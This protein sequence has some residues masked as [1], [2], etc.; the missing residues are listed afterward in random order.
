MRVF[1]ELIVPARRPMADGVW[2][3][4]SVS[5]VEIPS[6]ISLQSATGAAYDAEQQVWRVLTIEYLEDEGE[7]NDDEP[8]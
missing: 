7:V 4:S 8:F 6:N 1:R 3:E 2:G 5:P